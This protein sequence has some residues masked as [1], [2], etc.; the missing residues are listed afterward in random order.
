MT[1]LGARIYEKGDSRRVEWC[2]LDTSMPKIVAPAYGLPEWATL[3][4]MYDFGC[5]RFAACLP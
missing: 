5:E 3:R 2:S 4:G 1:S